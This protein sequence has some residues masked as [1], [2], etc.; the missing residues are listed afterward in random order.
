MM[1][2]KYLIIFLLI[3][4]F[5]S[6]ILVV[7]KL[8]DVGS[9]P[10]YQKKVWAKSFSIFM[11]TPDPIKS[12]FMIISGKRNFS[13]LFNDYNVKFLPQTQYLELHLIKKKIKFDK[14]T[15]LSFYIDFDENNL[16]LT[17]KKGKFF[18]SDLSNLI[19]DDKSLPHEELKTSGLLMPDEKNFQILDTL[20]IGSKLFVSKIS[21]YQNC[22]RLEIK[23]AEIKD[24]LKFNSLK[25][26]NECASIN[27]GAGRIDKFNFKGQEGILLT[28]N[29]S[30]N[31]VPG[32][33]AQDDDSIFGKIIFINLNTKKFEIFS[34][35]HRNAQGLS[36]NN[37]IV[38]STEHGPRGGDEINRI[39]YKKNYG[40]PIASYGNSYS[41][42]NLSYKK[43]HS[44]NLFEEPLFVFLPSIGISELIFLPNKFDKKWNENIL[45]SSLNG[46]SI[47]RIKFVD[48]KFEKVLYNEKIYIGERIRDI[49]Y[50]DKYNLIILALERTG[51]IGVLKK[52]D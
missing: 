42:K 46:R 47:H 9:I 13:N 49:K 2:K 41:D 16:I 10:K 5:I 32:S 37:D 17:T 18:K 38:I 31:D 33:K 40:W 20:I 14:D 22:E 25:L 24:D 15:R 51:S 11:A 34:K 19:N 52:L 26:F 43:S 36:V 44:K 6:S 35:G 23:F 8:S 28:T 39:Y 30:D 45:V 1:K 7:S 50:I 21:K 48:S 29:D 4:L 27:I 3:L 12:L